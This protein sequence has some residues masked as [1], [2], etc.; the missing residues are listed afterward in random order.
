MPDLRFVVTIVALLGTIVATLA[1]DAGTSVRV[2]GTITALQGTTLTVKNL[3]GME[4][5]ID[6]PESVA[7]A[8]TK[9]FSMADITPGMILGVTT[10]KRVDGADVAI[11]VH[12]IPATAPL[13]LI[14]WDLAPGST[15]NNGAVEA[16]VAATGGPE[17]TLNYKTGVV[18]VLIDKKTAMAQAAPGTRADLKAGETVFVFGNKDDAGKITAARV[19]VSKD[20]IKP[21]Q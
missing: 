14:P 2:R 5:S 18:K 15:M 11:E 16:T 12:P 10:I 17:L 19:Q 1:Q 13:G 8:A 9:P 20:G 21:V 6:V 4:V 3:A 7:V